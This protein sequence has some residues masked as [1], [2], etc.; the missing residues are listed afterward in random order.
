MAHSIAA[1]ML[2]HLCSIS[3]APPF[4]RPVAATRRL[5]LDSAASV[6][7]TATLADAG[8]TRLCPAASNTSDGS[9]PR[10]CQLMN[11][12]VAHGAVSIPATV[13]GDLVSDLQASG[14][15]ADPLVDTN[16]LNRTAAAL[17]NADGWK[18]TTEFEVTADLMASGDVQL[19]FESVK[20]GAYANLNGH[21]LGHLDTQFMRFSFPV[22]GLLRQGTNNLSVTFAVAVDTHGRYM[23]CTGGDDWAPYTPAL[24]QHSSLPGLNTSHAFTRGIV[25]SVYLAATAKGALLI[26]EVSPFVHHLGE[27]P[28][29]PLTARTAGPWLVEVCT[30]VLVPVAAAARGRLRVVGNWSD[31]AHAQSS[32]NALN[33]GRHAV[34]LN[35]TAA[36]PELWWPNGLGRQL[37]YTVSVTFTPS[38][39]SALAVNASATIGFRTLAFVTGND[40]DVSFRAAAATGDGNAGHTMMYRINGH[41]VLGLGSNIIPLDEMDARVSA[42]QIENLVASLKAASYTMVR[43]WGGGVYWPSSFYSALDRAGILVYHDLCVSGYQLA[44]PLFGSVV[45]FSLQASVYIPIVCSGVV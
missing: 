27:Y 1:L 4:D 10:N 12:S 30:H 38:G 34:C 42:A 19:T 39:S 28:T 2:L 18:Y 40:T 37:L 35:I 15:I 9:L 6:S 36:S 29:V 14:L 11:T 43:I 5:S 33:A 7:W 22:H 24:D 21:N 3:G 32:T 25:R 8:L 41:S 17:W 26:E 31:T 44:R 20:A 16:F 23:T 45:R 13:P